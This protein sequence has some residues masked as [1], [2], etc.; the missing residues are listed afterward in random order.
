MHPY[1]SLDV[2]LIVAILHLRLPFRPQNFASQCFA[3]LGLLLNAGCNI[4]NERVSLDLQI[5]I[6]SS[7][8]RRRPL[9]AGEILCKLFE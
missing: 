1:R 9:S 7:N 8:L 6:E 5:A 3:P 4:V 2:N